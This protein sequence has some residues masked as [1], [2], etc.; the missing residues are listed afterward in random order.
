MIVQISSK[1]G[2]S[3]TFDRCECSMPQGQAK[4]SGRGK[5]PTDSV[6]ASVNHKR[7]F[8]RQV[9]LSSPWV[10]SPACPEIVRFFNETGTWMRLPAG[11]G[12][13]NGGDR[14]EIAMVLSGLG[15]FSFLDRNGNNHIFALI[16]PGRLMGDVDG[17]AGTLVNVTDLAMRETEVRI[18]K[19][20]DFLAFLLVNPVIQHQ[21]FVGII[22][23]HESDMEGM[24]SNFTLSASERICALFESLMTQSGT[25]RSRNGWTEVPYFLTAVEISHVVSIARPTV[26]SILADWSRKGLIKRDGR[27]LFV[28]DAFFDMNYDWFDEGPSPAGR[29]RKRRR[30]VLQ[31]E[32]CQLPD[33]LPL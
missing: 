20:E 24:V 28:A 31:S 15:A 22:R 27:T 11:G 21:H 10:H 16:L 17:L 26:S 30:P 3:A 2:F 23:D 18:V 14:G 12:I 4:Y 13:L 33:G 8:M 1:K 19:K 5:R 25:C 6:L 9:F 7:E 29:I 32:K